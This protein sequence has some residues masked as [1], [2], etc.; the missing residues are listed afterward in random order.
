MTIQYS[1]TGKERKRLVAA[2]SEV[3]TQPKEYLGAPDYRYQ[4]GEYI[5]S[6]DGT[7][8]GPDNRELIAALAESH[9][10]AAI[11]GDYD[12][13]PEETPAFEELCLT[14]R[15]ELG[16][17]RERR[18]P[19][20][21]DGMQASDVPEPDTLT[22]EFPLTGFNPE[23]LDNLCKLV[24]SKEALLK[25]A[26]GAEEL[27]VQMLE[28][29]IA[30]PW[31][32]LAAPEHADAYAKFITALC[33]TAKEKKRVTAKAKESF[34]NEKFAM[35]VWLIGLGLIGKEFGLVRKLLMANLGGNSSWRYGAPNK[36]AQ[37]ADTAPDCADAGALMDSHP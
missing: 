15:E 28:D 17:G 26:L 37:E 35:R 23:T 21:E 20:G 3:L 33:K 7:V 24:L 4:V 12:D 1:V 8:T 29:R 22:V 14:E 36:A 11:V 19:I 31:F 5:I 34:E 30:F 9:G 25:K 13:S 6:H 16:F 2:I 10:F 27:P 18:D 32:T